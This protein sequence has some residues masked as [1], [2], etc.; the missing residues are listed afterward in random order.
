M[1]SV[2]ETNLAHAIRINQIITVQTYILLIPTVVVGTL[3]NMKY[4]KQRDPFKFR[5][6][7]KLAENSSTFPS[8]FPIGLFYTI[9]ND[10]CKVEDNSS[11]EINHDDNINQ[12]FKILISPPYGRTWTVSLFDFLL[13]SKQCERC[14]SIHTNMLWMLTRN[15]NVELRSFHSPERVIHWLIFSRRRI[16]MSNIFDP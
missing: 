12:Y 11:L 2:N 5:T 10:V 4:S 1:S 16:W 14:R 15:V 6:H 7:Q 8:T 13:E 3:V 9:T